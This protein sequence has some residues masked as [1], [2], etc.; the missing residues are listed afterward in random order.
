[1]T[2]QEKLNEIKRWFHISKEIQKE[3]PSNIY[4]QGF[5]DGAQF[6]YIQ[7]IEFLM[8]KA[9]QKNMYDWLWDI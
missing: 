9:E 8:T 4:S 3:N 7:V 5:Q 6:A 1:M 2:K